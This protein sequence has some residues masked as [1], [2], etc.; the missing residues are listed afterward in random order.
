ML[1]GGNYSDFSTSELASALGTLE[2]KSGSSKIAKRLFRR[3]LV[4]PTENSVAQAE[5][6]SRGLSGLELEITKFRVPRPFEALAW[7]N[8][9]KSQ[10]EAAVASS[11]EWL[12]DQAFSARPAIFASYLSSGVLE[13]YDDSITTIKSSLIPNPG[14]PS[15]INNLAFA[16][17]S[18]ARVDQAEEQLA[19]IDR[20]QI[21]P[22]SSVTLLATSGLIC[23]RKGM[24]EEG[25]RL[26]L[27][28][29]EEADR[30]SLPKHRAMA[31]LYLAREE[32]VADTPAKSEAV[33]RALAESKGQNDPDFLAIFSRVM[34]FAN[35]P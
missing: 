20:R 27:E 9:N 5:W 8:F 26:Y 16:L 10:W 30:H 2:F 23:F 4:Q 28:A 32:V 11:M 17:A 31:A 18:T 29:M 19:N 35:P 7:D 24:V 15:L 21:R 6:V 34:Q 3:S 22:V 13:R 1:K 33:K 12:R 14:D 25:R